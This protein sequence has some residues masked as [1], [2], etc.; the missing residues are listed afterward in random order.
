MRTRIIVVAGL[1]LAAIGATPARADFKD[2]SNRC[3]PG[4]MRTCASFQ[5]ST[6][7]VG[8]VTYVTL[9]ARNLQGGPAYLG[10]NTGGSVIRRIGLTAPIFSAWG[11]ANLNVAA[12]AGAS[13]I[14][15]AGS[16]WH[17]RDPGSIGG[18]LEL[19]LNPGGI[20]NPSFN[21]NGT[22]QG[23][24]APSSQPSARFETCN[25][26]WVVFTF[27]T[28]VAWSA[29]DAELG[30]INARFKNFGGQGF[31]CES[32]ATAGNTDGREVCPMVTPE[33]IT[34]VLLG[35]GLAGMGG[36]GLIRRR[37]GRD[38]ANG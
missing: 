2:F 3:S 16:Y 36:M 35:S 20:G 11:A 26:G 4:A 14:N 9:R 25:G 32:S 24:A 10:D 31:E 33:P 29:N 1:A 28:T 38:V 12:A 15:N 19:D 7:V 27:T 17:I 30:W 18:A 21:D 8:G 6:Q 37:R 5:L 23:C 34:M 22:I 13:N